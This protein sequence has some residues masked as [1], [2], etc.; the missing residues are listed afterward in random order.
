MKRNGHRGERSGTHRRGVRSPEH[1]I[2]VFR[3]RGLEMQLDTAK[4]ADLQVV[5]AF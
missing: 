2:E 5:D 4:L 1:E 3:W